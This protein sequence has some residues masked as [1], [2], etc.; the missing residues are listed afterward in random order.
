MSSGILLQNVAIMTTVGLIPQGWLLVQEDKIAALGTGN[1]PCLENVEIINGDGLTLLP[2]FIDIHVH[3][4]NG[5]DTMDATPT[6]YAEMAKFYAQHGVTSFLATTWADSFARIDAALA[7]VA[8]NLGP[9]PNGATLLG[10]HLEGPYL[11]RAKCGAQNLNYIRTASPD[12]AHHFLSHDVIRLISLAPEFEENHWLIKTC[13]ERGITVSVAHTAATYEDIKHAVTLGLSHS[14]HTYNAM[15]ELHHRHP[16]TVGAVMV[17]PQINCELIA[18]NIHVHP[19]A[20]NLLWLAKKPHGLILISDAMRATGLPDGIYQVDEREVIS[21]AG[22]VHLSD[23]TLAGSTLTLDIALK[24]FMVA[25]GEALDSV[26][27]TSS[28]NA[29]HAIKIADRKG[30]IDIGKDADL[31]LVDAAIQVHLTLAQ[32]KIVYRRDTP[33]I[34]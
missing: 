5:H 17:M 29:A 11:N 2:G 6:A 27:Q 19:A 7:S 18:D 22:I 33:C 14:T 34:S 1:P 25:T 16:G 32:G 4:A 20:M 10:V 28:L 15:T 31:V 12:E 9:Q 30:S 13:A 3:G 23:G 21:E 24:N 26:W 8:Q